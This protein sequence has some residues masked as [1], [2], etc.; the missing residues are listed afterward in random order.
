MQELVKCNKNLKDIPY[1]IGVDLALY[2]TGVC[3]YHPDTD[4]FSDLQEVQVPHET[5]TPMLTLFEGLADYFE[6][7]THKYGT[8]GMVVQEAMPAQA[9]PHSTINTLQAL[10]KAHG[11]LELCVCISDDLYR[12]D[13]TGVYSVSVK[14]MF[15]TEEIQKPT[16]QDIQA[17]L[18]E[19]YHCNFDGMSENISDAMGVVYTLVNRKWDN[20]IKDR[21][22]EVRKEIKGLKSAKAIAIHQIELQRLEELKI[23][24]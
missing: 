13:K 12:Y 14:S 16:K 9:G 15:K 4:T 10:A 3:V 24:K 2:R 8:G 7:V 18:I 23:N 22:R 11:I 19:L 20:D 17:K 5:D 1:I 21:Q 6:I